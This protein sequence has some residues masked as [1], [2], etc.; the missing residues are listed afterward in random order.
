MFEDLEQLART[1][2]IDPNDL[3]SPGTVSKKTN[4]NQKSIDQISDI[5]RKYGG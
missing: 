3:Q 4:H 1:M 5:L 2:G